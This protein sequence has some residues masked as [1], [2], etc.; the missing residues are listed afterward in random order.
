MAVRS[1]KLGLKISLPQNIQPEQTT[2]APKKE[3]VFETDKFGTLTVKNILPS[4]GSRA[5]VE[6]DKGTFYFYTTDYINKGKESEGKQFY[7]KAFIHPELRQQVDENSVAVNIQ[8]APNSIFTNKER[9]TLSNETGILIPKDVATDTVQRYTSIHDIDKN[10][11]ITGIS[12]GRYLLDNSGSKK[13]TYISTQTDPAANAQYFTPSEGGMFKSVFGNNILGNALQGVSDTLANV[14]DIGREGIEGVDAALQNEY[15]RAAIKVIATVAPNPVTRFAAAALDVYAPLD[16]GEN[17]SA[18]QIANLVMAGN[19]VFG[20]TAPVGGDV[21]VGVEGGAAIDAGAGAGLDFSGATGLEID[22]DLALGNVFDSEIGKLVTAGA[23]VIDGADALDVVLG[24]YGDDIAAGVTNVIGSVEGG[25][26]IAKVLKDNPEIAKTVLDVSK[27]TEVSEALANNFGDKVAGEL[28]AETTNEIA[29]VK[30]GLETAVS[31]DQGKDLGDA[32][33][34]GAKKSYEE[35]FRP[36]VSL[37]DAEGMGLTF[38]DLGIDLSGFSNFVGDI[39]ARFPTIPAL[40]LSL[41]E[42]GLSLPEIKGLGID[43]SGVE[44]PEVEI[45]EVAVKIPEVEFPEVEF[46]E[47]VKIFRK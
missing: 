28:G 41:F 22:A 17:P 4:D 45:P 15:V 3:T 32:F 20:T 12:N 29:L 6:T 37:P 7:S 36:D 10:G 46:P 14:E 11:R 40:A 8:D 43:I 24:V 19:N 35:G 33:F 47:G 18:G 9:T 42:G 26:E 34:E 21:G 27:G 39:N 31:L 13:T 16:S 1:N 44:F 30:G 38:S 2:Q 5:T 23:S 25:E